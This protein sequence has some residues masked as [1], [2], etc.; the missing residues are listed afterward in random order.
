MGHDSVQ[1][2]RQEV[3][4]TTHVLGQV[5]S[6]GILDAVLHLPRV[7][8]PPVRAH[9]LNDQDFWTTNDLGESLTVASL[10]VYNVA[11][12]IID[13]TS[14]RLALCPTS[15]VTGEVLPEIPMEVSGHFSVV[16]HLE[17][18]ANVFI[19]LLVS[20]TAVLAIPSRHCSEMEQAIY[21]GVPV[22]VL[23]LNG[24]AT[25]QRLRGVW[26]AR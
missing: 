17:G 7:P 2:V 23:V 15:C 24:L 21:G 5:Q 14:L 18:D 1:L 22:A 3:F 10:V 9:E 11:L 8:I 12:L 26:I 25:H 16:G 4:V 20:R 6:V 19:K 13:C